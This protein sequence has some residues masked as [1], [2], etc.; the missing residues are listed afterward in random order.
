MIKRDRFLGKMISLWIQDQTS[1]L[2]DGKLSRKVISMLEYTRNNEN[3]CYIF[4]IQLQ[5]FMRHCCLA[6]QRRSFGMDGG[7]P[8]P[9]LASN[10]ADV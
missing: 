3:P 4:K 10:F 6:G 7:L 9:G 5:S 1:P 8:E 2:L